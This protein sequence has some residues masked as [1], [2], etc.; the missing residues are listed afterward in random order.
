MLLVSFH[1]GC[2]LWDLFCR[3]DEYETAIR[4]LLLYKIGADVEKARG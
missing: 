2:S 4:A 3:W 1:V